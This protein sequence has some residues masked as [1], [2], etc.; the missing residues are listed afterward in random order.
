MIK[1][2]TGYGKGQAALDKVALTVEIRSVE[3][4]LQRHRGEGAARFTPA[5]RGD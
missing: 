5:R 2:M 1:S 4:S 3:P